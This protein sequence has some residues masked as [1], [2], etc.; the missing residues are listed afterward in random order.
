M[1]K[2]F[3]ISTFIFSLPKLSVLK[4]IRVYQKLF[5]PDHGP[6]RVLYPHGYCKFNPSCS[7]YTYEAVEKKGVTRGLILGTAR[8]LRCN[9]WSKGGYDPVPGKK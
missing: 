1:A 9:P 7:Q 2:Y 5:S 8:I 3:F 6:L 4:T